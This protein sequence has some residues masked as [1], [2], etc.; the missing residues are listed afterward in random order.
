MQLSQATLILHVGIIFAGPSI[1]MLWQGI[2][3]SLK[4]CRYYALPVLFASGFVKGSLVNAQA[5]Q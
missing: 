5:Y 3:D 2:L 4:F 1:M